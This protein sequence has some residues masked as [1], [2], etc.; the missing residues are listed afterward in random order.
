MAALIV[1]LATVQSGGKLL[2]AH[3]TDATIAV[4]VKGGK[5]KSPAKTSKAPKQEIGGPFSQCGGDNYKGKTCCKS[6]CACVRDSKFFSMCKPPTGLQT[7]NLVASKGEAKHA[8]DRERAAEMVLK[9]DSTNVTKAKRDAKKSVEVLKAAKD[10]AKNATKT[11]EAKD[12][13]E[14]KEVEAAK[15]DQSEV[16]T[17][18]MSSRK[19]FVNSAT[20][21]RSRVE[22]AAA[23]KL[24]NI[25]KTAKATQD[26]IVTKATKARNEAIQLAT[27]RRKQELEKAHAEMRSIEGDAKTKAIAK[28]K[29][30]TKE[31]VQSINGAI[32]VRDKA[33]KKATAEW[34]ATTNKAHFAKAKTAL[35]LKEAT[36]AS[37]AASKA[38]KNKAEEVKN[39]TDWV[40]FYNQQEEMRKT[41][42][43][44]TMW[45]DCRS[46]NCCSLGCK[47]QWHSKYYASCTGVFGSKDY[48][49]RDQVV[50][51]QTE[52]MK[53]LPGL[54]MEH[55]NLKEDAEKKAE[56]LADVQKKMDALDTKWAAALEAAK[57]N[58]SGVIAQA[59]KMYKAVEDSAVY[60]ENEL[61]GDANETETDTI[62]KERKKSNMAIQQAEQIAATVIA[63]ARKK[64]EDTITDI[65]DRTKA[66][67]KDATDEA[68]ST[69]NACKKKEKSL[70][71][72]A[73]KKE[74]DVTSSA[75]AKVRKTTAAAHKASQD[76]NDV[77]KQAI[78][79][80]HK[81]KSKAEAALKHLQHAMKIMNAK[82]QKHTM[83]KL[84]VQ[85]WVNAGKGA[86][87][88]KP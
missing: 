30:A 81:E 75:M 71:E 69:I 25:T 43:C 82:R 13:R 9:D 62:S 36:A 55:K 88:C 3:E 27:A 46:F 23:E 19:A 7:C 52:S 21:E 86:T 10:V 26:R 56:V 32:S 42:T 51:K 47:C 67:I 20:E 33:I 29:A 14:K 53:V 8:R 87:S 72:A 37:A 49:E 35:A 73:L 70:I 54:Q 18:A 39:V 5:E 84:E 68:T 22:H 1:V 76:A 63:A 58:E 16:F 34:T 28:R 57:K 12:A 41:K 11:W 66:T 44:G 31:R 40:T 80:V 65:L 17:S 64:A 4:A 24:A 79:H 59:R 45:K 78:D 2:S 48:C 60:K 74:K 15:H 77:R 50:A 6:G 38:L 85:T 61:I 83:A